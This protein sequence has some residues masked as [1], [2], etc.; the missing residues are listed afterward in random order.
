MLALQTDKKNLK[1]LPAVAQLYSRS[2][3]N[4]EAWAQ[5]Q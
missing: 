3:S 1:L 5:A 4:L 2:H